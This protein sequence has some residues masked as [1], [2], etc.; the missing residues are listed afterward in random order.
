M[1][2]PVPVPRLPRLPFSLPLSNL[3]SERAL[4]RGHGAVLNGI[5]VGGRRL[6]SLQ[7]SSVGGAARAVRVPVRVLQLCCSTNISAGG[8]RRS[9]RSEAATADCRCMCGSGAECG[10]RVA[11]VEST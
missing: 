3:R 7:C 10:R 5:D 8:W 2:Q 6:R 1:Q 9:C 4:Q 11:R